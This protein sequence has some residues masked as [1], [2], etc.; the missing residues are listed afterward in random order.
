MTDDNFDFAVGVSSHGQR[1]I[2][3]SRL[4]NIE[5]LL[6][7]QMAYVAK[8]PF[9]DGNITKLKQEL[10]QHCGKELL[11][12]EDF[13]YKKG[14]LDKA[15]RQAQERKVKLAKQQVL[16]D[17]LAALA[18]EHGITVAQLALAWVLCNRLCAL[19]AE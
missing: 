3:N 14:E 6:A 11:W 8:C 1:H 16:L 2:S 4:A 15:Q 19:L 13:V 17:E 7:K 18:D 12:H 10:C 5:R 9:C